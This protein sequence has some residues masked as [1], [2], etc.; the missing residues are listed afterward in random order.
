MS[1]N[2]RLSLERFIIAFTAKVGLK[3]AF[4]KIERNLFDI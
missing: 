1:G 2:R 4:F 3:F